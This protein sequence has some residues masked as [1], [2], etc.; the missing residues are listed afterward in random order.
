[1]RA[2]ERILP[3]VIEHM[4]EAIREAQGREVLFVGRLDRE[5]RV[6]EVVVA[7]RGD[8][9]SVPALAPHMEKGEVVLHNHPDT[10]GVSTAAN[11]RP[12]EADLHIASQLGNQG[13]GFFIVDNQI[14]EL[15]AVAE[16]VQAAE[17]QMLAEDELAGILEPGGALSRKMP[18]YEARESQ[19]NMLKFTVQAFNEGG[20]FIAEAGTGVGK[21]LAYLLPA[22][23]WVCRN[24]ERVV[25]STATINL[26][27]Q[28]MDKD[29]PLVRRLLG[30][31]VRAVL[32]KGRGNYLCRARL[33]EALDEKNLFEEEANTVLDSLEKWAAETPTGSRSDLSFFPGEGVWSQV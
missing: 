28:L 9:T 23:A 17:I 15:Y 7:A 2:S 24:E 20:I 27:E 26:Q 1:M 14:R 6:R 13:I 19:I 25:V 10:P 32:V 11:L 29:I 4:R 22:L 33:K 31:D 30:R 8:E 5:A 21:S 3:P 16:P 12:S 18:G